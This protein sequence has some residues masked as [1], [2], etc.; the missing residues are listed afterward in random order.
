LIEI[1]DISD[2][3]EA[4]YKLDFTKFNRQQKLTWNHI[5]GAFQDHSFRSNH[6]NPFAP[7]NNSF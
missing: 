4:A 3:D 6:F 2:D 7:Q 1:P 5:A